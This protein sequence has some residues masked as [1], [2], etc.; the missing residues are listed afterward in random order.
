EL[1]EGG[2]LLLLKVTPT[3]S[4]LGVGAGDA[5]DTDAILW[6]RAQ[7][8]SSS[9]GVGLMAQ[10]STDPTSPRASLLLPAL[11]TRHTISPSTLTPP[12]CSQARATTTAS[13]P[14]TTPSARSAPS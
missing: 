13:W 3:D 2:Q 11:P 4:F 8:V 7:D 12:V 14:V 6:T 9:A 5:T 10:V 1:V